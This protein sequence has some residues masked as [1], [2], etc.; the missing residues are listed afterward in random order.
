QFTYSPSS[1]DTYLDCPRQIYFR[2]VM[3]LQEKTDLLATPEPRE[4]GTFVHELLHQTFAEFINKKPVIDAVFEA[5][6][7]KAFKKK[8]EEDFHPRL[9]DGA[10]LL[11]SVLKHRLEQFLRNEQE[12]N[13][14]KLIV[15]EQ[16]YHYKIGDFK[17]VAKVDRVDELDDGTLLVVDYKTG[18]KVELP[19]KLQ[20]LREM[21]LDRQA[22]K[23]TIKTFQMPIYI[24]IFRD[25]QPGREVNACL[26]NLRETRLSM[27]FK[28]MEA[29]EKAESL[30][31]IMA[32]AQNLIKE[33]IDPAVPFTADFTDAW[34]CENCSF[35]SLCR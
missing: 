29:A 21:P 9:G 13:V 18:G 34:Q 32:A 26:Y 25:S 35:K 20:K 31:L 15:L 5:K 2:Y 27:C 14:A 19:A 28:K 16:K 7:F 4:I 1:L 11:E 22:M 17:L 8:F 33:I 30:E 23:K 6:F 12:R 10:F 3:F 24:S